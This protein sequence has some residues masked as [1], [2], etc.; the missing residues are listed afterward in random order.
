MM[1]NMKYRQTI[2]YRIF[3]VLLS[4]A[5]MFNFTLPVRAEAI[6]GLPTLGA[7]IGL[8]SSYN[9]L[10]LRGVTLFPKNPLA[11]DFIMDTGDTNL[12]P[13]ALKDESTKLIKYFLTAL[14]VPKNEMWV[15]LSPEERNRIAPRALGHTQMGYD[16][17]AQDYVLKQLSASLT[18]PEEELGQEF[19]EAVYSQAEEKYGTTQLPTNL[20]HKI[21]IVP[22]KAVVYV[23]QKNIFVLEN[24]LKVMLESDYWEKEKSSLKVNQ[25]DS[26]IPIKDLMKKEDIS[27][28]II[29]EIILP[30]IEKEVNYGKT[31]ANLR[32]I[33]S[34]SILATW[35][36]QN[37][38][39]SLMRRQY[40][41]QNKIDG[42]TIKDKDSKLKIH[43]QYVAALRKGVYNFM[44]EEYDSLEKRMIARKYFSGGADLEK[45]DEAMTVK[46]SSKTKGKDI[47]AKIA[48]WK[49]LNVPTVLKGVVTT[50]GDLIPLK[51][52]PSIKKL[53]RASSGQLEKLSSDLKFLT[54]LSRSL[55]RAYEE[56]KDLVLLELAGNAKETGISDVMNQLRFKRLG[57]GF[58]SKGNVAGALDILSSKQVNKDW[59]D[60]KT[61]IKNF[62][63]SKKREDIIR[64]NVL[65]LA[66]LKN[67]NKI[68]GINIH[69]IKEMVNWFFI[70][71]TLVEKIHHDPYS[72]GIIIE[73]IKEKDC[74]LTLE[75]LDAWIQAYPLQR[76]TVSKYVAAIALEALKSQRFDITAQHVMKWVNNVGYLRD[77]FAVE[78]AGDIILEALRQNIYGI[79]QQNLRDIIDTPTGDSVQ[80]IDLAY[81]AM[82]GGY[83]GISEDDL[84][85]LAERI[86]KDSYPRGHTTLIKAFYHL[87]Q[88]D[89]SEVKKIMSGPRGKSFWTLPELAISGAI[90][91]ITPEDVLTWLELLKQDRRLPYLYK[92][93]FD[94]LIET[95]PEGFD[96]TFF[97]KA[98]AI[99][100]EA[101]HYA[102]AARIAILI[103][104]KKKMTKLG[105]SVVE[106]SRQMDPSKHKDGIFFS[107]TIRYAIDHDKLNKLQGIWEASF[108]NGYLVNMFDHFRSARLTDEFLKKIFADNDFKPLEVLFEKLSSSDS[109]ML[110][111]ETIDVSNPL[112]EMFL[113]SRV[114]FD[115][116]SFSQNENSFLQ[117]Y[118]Q[119]EEDV[120]KGLIKSLPDD[121]PEPITISVPIK[122]LADF[123]PDA[124]RHYGNFQK[125]IQAALDTIANEPSGLY[126][127]APIQ[128]LIIV[129]SE[130]LPIYLEK[131]SQGTIAHLQSAKSKLEASLSTEPERMALLYL[132]AEELAALGKIKDAADIIR[133]MLLILALLMNDNERS[134]FRSH[135][136]DP[137]SMEAVNHIIFFADSI[138]KPHVLNRFEEE[139][140]IFLTKYV[141]VHM[142]K[143]EIELLEQKKGKG[144][145]RIKIIPTRGWIA[146][147]VGY[148]AEECWTDTFNVMR[149]NPNMMA[150][151]FV[152]EDTNELLGGTYLIENHLNGEKDQKEEKVIIERGLSPRIDFTSQIIVKSFV[153]QVMYYIESIA[154]GAEA[155]KILIL[156]REL[157]DGLGTNNPDIIDYYEKSVEDMTTVTLYE[158]VDFNDHDI[159][160]DNLVVY[161]EVNLSKPQDN[162]LAVTADTTKGGIDLA[163]SDFFVETKG[164]PIVFDLEAN[165]DVLKQPSFNGF[166]PVIQNI[167]PVANLHF[168]LGI[169]NYTNYIK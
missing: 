106:Q 77:D 158:I 138:I 87:P 146:E 49:L 164:T 44:K 92:T 86:D 134:Y 151:I 68:E 140:K 125:S 53:L 163:P 145:R 22:N 103:L 149:D 32:Q 31:F 91:G 127:R 116:S 82:K 75:E 139:K 19:W 108:S 104:A 54:I 30:A 84:N 153:D 34:A 41:D 33:Y 109:Q 99:I 154:R 83:A 131:G 128:N 155:E 67:K 39:E 169:P 73:L 47:A 122:K 102:L 56:G 81:K 60:I 156:L 105:K 25:G 5:S 7:R 20:L 142:F 6:V 162:A 45:L 24:S 143:K 23:H 148:F 13:E 55:N 27:T 85:G 51:T 165:M 150:L 96:D 126:Y 135:A 9:P 90:E 137:I 17:L 101:D 63:K 168:L 118:R 3:S 159:T 119:Y 28:E 12:S 18:S 10:L 43:D 97:V 8:S 120:K 14:T 89:Y 130:A 40:I 78:K 42:V 1:K 93:V 66:V 167:T 161:R 152:D 38:T 141:N 71:K 112:V 70:E 48:S 114:R 80:K 79:T 74:P 57:Q 35:Y 16:L 111:D 46:D 157:E 98:C 59:Q 107:E 147:F 136:M 121:Y 29:R 64:S 26:D 52:A 129:I 166:I 132:E 113:R 110:I 15:N 36:K 117:M 37:L 50:E 62:R 58:L 133:H 94:K 95:R 69:E 72:S 100:L 160:E 144:F 88:V 2:K 4:I 21:W 76:S 115:I 123:S 61:R 11:F 124:K 65:I